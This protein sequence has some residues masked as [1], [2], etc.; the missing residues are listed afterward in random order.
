MVNPCRIC[1]PFHI[2]AGITICKPNQPIGILFRNQ[3]CGDSVCLRF[4]VEFIIVIVIRAAVKTVT[5]ITGNIRIR[6]CFYRKCGVVLHDAFIGVCPQDLFDVQI[7]Q[8]VVILRIG[9]RFIFRCC[10]RF[11]RIIN[12][13][14]K[15]FRFDI[16]GTCNN[17]RFIRFGNWS[18]VRFFK[19][20]HIRIVRAF[21]R[22][23]GFRSLGRLHHFRVCFQP[24]I[25][26]EMRVFRI[27]CRAETCGQRKHKN[28]CAEYQKPMMEA[29]HSEPSCI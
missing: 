23:L 11:S 9:I 5:P 24:L 2:K 6:N 3:N 17:I 19:H 12:R 1:N 26:P 21:Y 18:T 14:S 22:S 20:K 27:C 25:P 4:C 8:I 7:I 10:G 16:F 13:D 29:L 28:Q 15:V